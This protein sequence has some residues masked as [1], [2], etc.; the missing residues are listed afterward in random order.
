MFATPAGAQVRGVYPLGMNATNS[1]VTPDSGF[2]YSNLLLYYERDR[3][4]GADGETVEAGRNSV[5]LDM[6]TVVWVSD[7]L[8]WL[9]GAKF[10][11][12]A[13]VPIAKNSLTSDE[14]G[15]ISGATG[16][17]DI[18][19]QPLILGWQTGRADIRLIYGFLA[20]TGRFNAGANDNVGSGYWTHALASGQTFYLTEDRATAISAFEMYE[21]HETQEGTHI[22]PGDAL[23][24]DYSVT[25]VFPLQNDWRL[26]LGF[27]GYEGWQTSAKT[28]PRIT[29]SE[30][31][32]RYRV[33]ALGLASNL[34]VPARK[35]T[36]G[37]KFFKEFSSRSTFEGYS[38][39]GAIAI[40]F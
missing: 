5:A 7:K 30:S 14:V 9:G 10:S 24:L 19:I 6:N 25:R 18:Y 13:T 1:G 4:S 28:G 32:A 17:G 21:F 2:G 20:P 37:F 3:L 26:Q 15:Q 11:A 36:F 8:G 16:L 23:N 31:D 34:V 40:K 39:Q 22:H 35:L 38:L 12:V 27:A 29:P 33:D